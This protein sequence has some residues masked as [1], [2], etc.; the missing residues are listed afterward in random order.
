MNTQ[1]AGLHGA[2]RWSLS[3][4]M[5]VVIGPMSDPNAGSA[6]AVQATKQ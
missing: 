2:G 4:Q 1:T 3:E 5:Y 6:G